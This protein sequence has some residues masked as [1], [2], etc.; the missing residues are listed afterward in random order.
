MHIPVTRMFNDGDIVGGLDGDTGIVRLFEDFDPDTMQ[1]ALGYRVNPEDVVECDG[2][3]TIK[4]MTV[5]E[6]SIVPRY[7]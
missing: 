7:R 1:F 6:I 5:R 3:R 4:K 2:V